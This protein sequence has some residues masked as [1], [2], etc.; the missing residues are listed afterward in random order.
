MTD[1][2]RSAP[3]AL[4]NREPILAVLS[5]V[6]PRAGLV[7]TIAEGTGEH[8]VFFARHLPALEWQ[9]SDRDPGALTSVAAWID[10][11]HDLANVRAPVQV[12]V[13]DESWPV[14]RADAVV[15]INMIHASPWESTPAL[16]RG[17]SRILPP[18]A[19]LVLYGAYRIGGAHTAPSNV[20]FDAWLAER[21][22]RWAVRDLERVL[23][24]AAE[25]G[26]GHEETIPMP[27][28]NFMIV[29]RRGRDRDGVLP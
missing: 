2:R 26:L 4:N 6:L 29:L 10:H 27:A 19:P 9:P 8:V 17:A 25:N 21:D 1:L 20:G 16:M 7:L 14:D 3:A 24:V 15:C 23:D 5:R 12:D 11:E 18:G 22:P 13:A 28:N